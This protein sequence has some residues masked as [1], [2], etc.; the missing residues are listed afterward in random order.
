M[1][2]IKWFMCFAANT[3]INVHMNIFSWHIN[4]NRLM[5]QTYTPILMR[6][7]NMCSFTFNL[8]HIGKLNCV[9]V[10]VCKVWA[11]LMYTVVWVSDVNTCLYIRAHNLNETLRKKNLATENNTFTKMM[12]LSKLSIF[13]IRVNVIHYSMDDD[14]KPNGIWSICSLSTEC[15]CSVPLASRQ[16]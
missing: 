10:C 6:I 9:C 3:C 16:I 2:R 12:N 14:A 11:N 8:N 13:G 15:P 1:F 5:L 4:M 7:F